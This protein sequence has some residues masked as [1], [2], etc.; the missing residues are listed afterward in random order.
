MRGIPWIA[1]DLLAPQEGLCCM[2][3]VF[4]DRVFSH[5]VMSDTSKRMACGWG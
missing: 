3:S 1:E 4:K 2:E 5:F